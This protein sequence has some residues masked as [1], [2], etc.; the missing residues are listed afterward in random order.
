MG[1][2]IYS[3]FCYVGCLIL[4]FVCA[5][6]YEKACVKRNKYIWLLVTYVIVVG[7]CSLRYYVGNDYIRYVEGFYLI[8]EYHKENVML[9]EPAYFALNYLFSDYYA[10]Y[11][12]V[13]AISSAISFFFIFKALCHR[14]ILKWGLFF[15][16]TMGTLIFVNNGIRQG[17]ALSIFIY[18]LRFIEER[19]FVKYLL[20]IFLAMTFHLSAFV[21]ILVYWIKYI[22][23]SS[24]A[25]FLLLLFCLLLQL[26]GVWQ[27]LF[28]AILPHIPFY[29]GYVQKMD[30]YVVSDLP[31][32]GIM[33]N[34][35]IAL[36]VA[37]T[38]KQPS[39]NIILTIF[40]TGNVLYIFSIGL[41][42]FERIAFYLLYTNI[43]IMPLY[44]L[45]RRYHQIGRLFV[46]MSFVYFAVQSLTGMEKH[47]AVP[48]RTI[49]NEDLLNPPKDYV[50]E[51]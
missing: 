22:R 35:I 10:G 26:L 46:F 30:N 44:V 13:F 49:F 51:E 7:F 34:V 6:R 37:I 38:Y 17:V 47:G 36:F 31:G 16:F 4:A 15:A 28:L 11:L 8:N 29:M 32:I 23:L 43:I 1:F 2:D 14:H 25:W 20:C 39:S 48:Y 27:K 12:Y 40:L 18:A 41:A 21:L 9:W 24:W 33:F 42:L 45:Q 5:K 3:C 50:E 19:R